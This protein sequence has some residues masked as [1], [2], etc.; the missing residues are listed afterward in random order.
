MEDD[1]RSRIK[2]VAQ[3]SPKVQE[4]ISLLYSEYTNKLKPLL[5]FEESVQ[6]LFSMKFGR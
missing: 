3:L 1:N 2:C 4:A 5:A 6:D